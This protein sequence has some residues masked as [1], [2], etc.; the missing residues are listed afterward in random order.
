MSL[1]MYV[2][3]CLSLCI[4]SWTTIKWSVA[5]V[6]ADIVVKFRPVVSCRYF[7]HC[8]ISPQMCHPTIEALSS[9]FSTTK[10]GFFSSS[11]FFRRRSTV[12]P[13]GDGST[14]SVSSIHACTACLPLLGRFREQD[15]ERSRGKG[16]SASPLTRHGTCQTCQTAEKLEHV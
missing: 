5:Y 8:F 3:I 16:T 6:R 12:F 10:R 14:C 4:H 13:L 1:F 7:W 11:L 15:T 2:F 9:T